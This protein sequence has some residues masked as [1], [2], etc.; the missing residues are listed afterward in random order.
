MRKF[1]CE[2]CGFEYEEE[3]GN[4]ESGILPMTKWE[5]IPPSWSCPD[6]GMSKDNFNLVE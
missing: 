6:C 1:M 3:A 2:M 4:P 5:N